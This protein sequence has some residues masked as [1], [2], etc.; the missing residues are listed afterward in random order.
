[1]ASTPLVR[2]R[3][4][5]PFALTL[6]ALALLTYAAVFQ[7]QLP[8]D[9]LDWSPITGEV[10]DVDPRGPAAGQ[11]SAGERILSIEGVPAAQAAH[12][13]ANFQ[14]GD[15]V[16]MQVRGAA[17][18]RQVVLVMRA[19]SAARVAQ[20][21]AP[22]VVALAFLAIGSLVLA[23]GGARPQVGLFFLFSLLGASVLASGSLSTKG[24]LWTSALFNILLRLAGPV[25][26]HLH[27]HFPEERAGP[28]WRRLL[29][30]L[31]AAAALLGLPFLLFGSTAIQASP[32]N[33]TL[34]AA[35]RSFLGLNLLLVVLLL[36]RS[37][38]RA[39][40]VQARQKIRLVA[41]GGSLA[42]LLVIA[43]I[44]G[45][46][47]LILR[48]FVP[49]EVGLFF[50]IILPLA[51]GYAILRHRLIQLEG[52]VSR[53]A[54]YTLVFVAL[55]AI[56]LALAGLVLRL[57][58][59]RWLQS[60]LVN[61]LQVLVLAASAVPLYRRI[62]SLV[63]W[64]FYGG[65]YDYRSAVERITAGLSGLKDAEALSGQLTERLRSTLRLDSAFLFI[66]ARGEALTLQLGVTGDGAAG[67]NPDLLASLPAEG[68]AAEFLR[69]RPEPLSGEELRANLVQKPLTRAEQFSLD[70]LR[71][72]LLV[73][74]T[75]SD[76]L[77]GLLA[78]GR[79]RAGEWFSAEDYGILRIVARHTAAALENIQLLRE[80]KLHA[81]EVEKLHRQL[82]HARE[83]ERKF[84]ARELHDEAIQ[85]LVGLNYRLAQMP[86]GAAD[87]IQEEVRRIVEDLRAMIRALRPPA[88]DNFGLVT[89]IRSHVRELGG[90][91]ENAPRIDLQVEG[92]AERWLPE[93]VQLC[94]YRVLQE[95]LANV[96]RH[97]LARHVQ[98]VLDVQ[99]RQ[100]SLEIRDD[101]RG[102]RI[103]QP[104]GTLLEQDHFGLV[105]L[106]ERLELVHGTLQIWSAPGEGTRLAAS[107]PL[108]GEVLDA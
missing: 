89:A 41:L 94:L 91:G 12:L 2:L 105:G 38:R 8:Y 4:A 106:R 61:M 1:M 18:E 68:A 26:V 76:R 42:L 103:P 49:Y 66:P 84:L 92:D 45:P 70:L 14:A 51:Y 52:L 47:V 48:A 65:W 11:V 25:S 98:V 87:D 83:D 86:D 102:F 36:V 19:P 108:P 63:D 58:P 16:A 78:L 40:S 107:V 85:A 22:L 56:Y 28:R 73:P 46:D 79:R 100:V 93:D 99:P 44:V 34:F 55:V 43:L 23:F 54:A 75:D 17:G 3:T 60:P 10:L 6:A 74:I 88:L 57:V 24:P 104:L 20:R 39:G 62:Q 27:L 80:L 71:G 77:L 59:S 21:L 69:L 50:L 82:L 7:T 95:A 5:A 96:D 81:A 31:Y 15:R 13:Y 35:G 64:V 101:G 30:L 53:G 90:L 32:L 33:A 37:Y 97:A 67:L 9:G 72:C 29:I